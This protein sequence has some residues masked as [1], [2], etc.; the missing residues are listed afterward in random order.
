MENKHTVQLQS[1]KD[2]KDE[3]QTVVSRQNSIIEELEKQLVTATA[4]NSFLQKQ[5][6]DLKETVQNLF[7]MISTP[8]RK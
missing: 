2:E 8:N 3:L 4:N 7:S 6:H 1:I 5:Q